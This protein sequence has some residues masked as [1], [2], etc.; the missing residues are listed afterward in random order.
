[1][2]YWDLTLVGSSP[3]VMLR[4]ELWQESQNLGANTSYVRFKLSFLTSGG[5][6]TGTWDYYIDVDGARRATSSFGGTHSGWQTVVDSGIT[7]SHDGNGNR[8]VGAYGW[9]DVYFGS[10]GTGGTI[11]LSRLGIAPT[12]NAPT[13][14]NVSVISARVNAS[15]SSWG[16]PSSAHGSPYNI[17]YRKSGGSWVERG[18]GGSTWDL[19]GLEPG[20]T[21][22]M[23]SRA[24]NSYGDESGW[25]TGTYTFTTLPAP[26]TS[27]ALLKIV[28]V[29]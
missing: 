8:S 16:R 21:Y 12:N 15:V 14:S 22:E 20:A 4:V 28:G 2:A 24:R 1:M 27:A 26:N 11:T 5:S 13:A 25:T 17:R 7:V 9:G 10:G 29:L 19:S 23:S 18:W 6:R 3:T